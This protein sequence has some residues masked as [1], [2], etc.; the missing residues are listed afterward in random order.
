MSDL[1][2]KWRCNTRTQHI[3]ET[4]CKRRSV[5]RH[6][7]S[8]QITTVAVCSAAVKSGRRMQ[9]VQSGK[10]RPTVFW[11]CTMWRVPVGRRGCCERVWGIT[12]AELIF[13]LFYTLPLMRCHLLGPFI[14]FISSFFTWFHFFYCCD[15][16]FCCPSFYC[17]GSFIRWRPFIALCCVSSLFFFLGPNFIFIF[18]MTSVLFLC[19]NHQISA[20]RPAENIIMTWNGRESVMSHSS[21]KLPR[22][23]MS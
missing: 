2:N 19:S 21:W 4:H 16:F 5:F 6:T 15:S 20:V 13:Y 1:I 3:S 8:S 10:R 14:L 17:L 11:V 22:F 7:P 18:N 23:E 12:G 9:C